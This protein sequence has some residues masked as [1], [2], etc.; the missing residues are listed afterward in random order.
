[1]P[2]TECC[3]PSLVVIDLPHTPGQRVLGQAGIALERPTLRIGCGQ[4]FDVG[5]RPRGTSL[6][7]WNP[8][9]RISGASEL[10]S[11]TRPHGQPCASWRRATVSPVEHEQGF[12]PLHDGQTS[13][14]ERGR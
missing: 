11:W 4:R 8:S 3:A 12:R 13:G 7:L 5:S 6:P 14:L 10:P 1:M 9:T 2:T